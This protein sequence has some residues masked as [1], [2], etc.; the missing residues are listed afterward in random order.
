MARTGRA[1]GARSKDRQ[2]QARIA[3]PIPLRA[4]PPGL[5]V[6]APAGLLARGSRAARRLPGALPSGMMAGRSPHTV[7]GAAPVRPACDAD[8]PNSLFVPCGTPAAPDGPARPRLSTESSPRLTASGALARSASSRGKRAPPKTGAT[9][10]G[11]RRRPGGRK[12]R[13][14]IPH[15]ERARWRTGDARRIRTAR[16]VSASRC[17]VRRRRPVPPP[18]NSISCRRCC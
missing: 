7:A 9:G 6:H 1:P 5:S 15:Q 2:R 11:D 18:R 14:P 4:T 3:H 10:F 8:L 17:A 12:A 13:A 16:R